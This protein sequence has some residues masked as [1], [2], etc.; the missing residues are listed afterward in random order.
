MTTTEMEDFEIKE[1]DRAAMRKKPKCAQCDSPVKT[2]Y[3][4][5]G[6]PRRE[7][8]ILFTCHGETAPMKVSFL[9]CDT[10]GTITATA[11][12]RMPLLVFDR[13]N[14]TQCHG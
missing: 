5:D 8:T 2:W 13:K 12:A 10:L 7:Y 11:I 14:E 4:R 9:G 6:S 3:R 1:L